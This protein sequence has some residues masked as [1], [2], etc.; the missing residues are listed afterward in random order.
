MGGVTLGAFL[1]GGASRP[2]P[3]PALDA[4]LD[5]LRE[6]VDAYAALRPG[7]R[8]YLLRPDGVTTL[9]LP[10]AR[11]VA[12]WHEEAAER[13]EAAAA[14]QLAAHVEDLRAHLPA[15]AAR[16]ARERA[17]AIDQRAWEA[18][19]DPV[20]RCPRRPLGGAYRGR[21]VWLYH[22]TTSI[23]LPGILREG[24]RHDAPKRLRVEETRG[25]VFLTA[26]P[27]GRL[28]WGEAPGARMY[29]E[30]AASVGG[31]DPVVLRVIVPWDWLTP[32]QDDTDLSCAHY[33]WEL[34]STIPPAQIMEADGVRLRGPLA[35]DE[36]WRAGYVGPRDAR[37]RAGP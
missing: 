30:R 8:P 5:A 23:K 33:Q 35:D 36:S 27:L 7:V 20:P 3:S 21:L 29:A 12:A 17:E 9:F 15:E 14:A 16:V 4:G 19:A 11:S 10:H 1:R 13:G 6:V 34:A 22:G 24:L 37:R 25:R 28:G 31:G 26:N 2:N 32:D 18:Q